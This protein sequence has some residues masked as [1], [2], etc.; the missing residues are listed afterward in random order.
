[1]WGLIGYAS[2][3]AGIDIISLGTVKGVFTKALPFWMLFVAVAVY[4]IQPLLF[5]HAMTFEG[6]AVMNSLWDLI[7]GILVTLV[8][9][10]YFKEKITTTKL[11]G[12]L[13][14]ILA[15][16]LLGMDN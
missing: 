1:M 9:L 13:F 16:G 5:Y 10:F 3:M 7:S 2:I 4:A 12:I 6:L 8:A 15:V 14:S 11:V